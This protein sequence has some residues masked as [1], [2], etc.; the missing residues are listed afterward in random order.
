MD[1]VC[2]RLLV[3]RSI[4]DKAGIANATE[5][6]F[7]RRSPLYEVRL[8]CDLYI[9]QDVIAY[10]FASRWSECSGCGERSLTVFKPPAL[11]TKSGP[12]PTGMEMSV[13]TCLSSV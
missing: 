9:R 7:V 2:F 12:I 8:S 11:N 3:E 5:E 1:L 6:F 10:D 13:S 4:T